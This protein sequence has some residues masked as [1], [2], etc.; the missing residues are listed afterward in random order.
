MQCH[1]QGGGDLISITSSAE[2][3]WVMANPLAGKTETHSWIGLSDLLVEGEYKW[4]EGTTQSY[5]NWFTNRP[6]DADDSSTVKD[7][8]NL[9][10]Q[11]GQWDDNDCT[12]KKHYICQAPEKGSSTA[13]TASSTATST[14]TSTASSTSSVCNCG[15]GWQGNVDTGACYKA[16][17]TD[18]KVNTYT[19]AD[20][21]CKV[22]PPSSP[23]EISQ[24][25]YYCI[26]GSWRHS[27]QH[28]LRHGERLRLEQLRE[29]GQ[30]LAGRD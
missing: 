25:S 13:S 1:C 26:S 19:K 6:N 3:A 16:S 22:T 4:S 9:R 17:G 23:P 30:H 29:G 28:H 15:E 14:A 2:N 18:T 24:I 20:T 12:S 10:N 11:D 21:A 8:V 27:H 7:C 5:L